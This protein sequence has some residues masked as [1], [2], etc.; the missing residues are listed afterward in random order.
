M[1]SL[2]MAKPTRPTEKELKATLALHGYELVRWNG[3][4]RVRPFVGGR[5]WWMTPFEIPRKEF[6]GQERPEWESTFSISDIAEWV[7][8]LPP[9]S[10]RARNT[11][12][13]RETGLA[14][15][16]RAPGRK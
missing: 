8:S 16:S 6:S 7:S 10:N 12:H 4:Y 5:N 3:R 15:Q 2:S 13:E 11:T 9:M 14:G 1:R